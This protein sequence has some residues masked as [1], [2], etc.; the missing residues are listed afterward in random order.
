MDCFVV[1]NDDVH[2]HGTVRT[3]L[4]CGVRNKCA[5]RPSNPLV[6]PYH[7]VNVGKV[8]CFLG[9]AYRWTSRILIPRNLLTSTIV[10]LVTG[11]LLPQALA[12]SVCDG[13]VLE[14]PPK[15]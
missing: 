11:D 15:E 4:P 8:W 7:S 13:F 2:V 3:R 10:V 9:G 6:L 14:L 5:L 1:D 12:E